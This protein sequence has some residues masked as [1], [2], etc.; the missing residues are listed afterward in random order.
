MR[1]QIFQN[2][3]ANWIAERLEHLYQSFLF[4]ARDVERTAGGRAGWLPSSCSHGGDFLYRIFTILYN[5]NSIHAS[6]VYLTDAV[7]DS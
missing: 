2:L 7:F 4:S 1:D 3:E 5:R 6:V